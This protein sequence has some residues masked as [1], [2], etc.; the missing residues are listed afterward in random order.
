MLVASLDYTTY[1]VLGYVYMA[2]FLYENSLISTDMLSV[3]TNTTT[4]MQCF[5]NTDL[6]ENGYFHSLGAI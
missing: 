6:M 3:Y 4:E 1:I 5:E 2:A